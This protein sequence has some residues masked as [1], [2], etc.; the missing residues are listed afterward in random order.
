MQ[1]GRE[2]CFVDCQAG[3]LLP[4]ACRWLGGGSPL[5]AAREPVPSEPRRQDPEPGG[6]PLHL[7]GMNPPP[8]R[9]GRLR[10]RWRRDAQPVRRVRVEKFTEANRQP[11]DSRQAPFADPKLGLPS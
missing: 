2:L 8:R 11:P 7:S 5:S 1:A 4:L 3:P 9:D 6:A 10:T